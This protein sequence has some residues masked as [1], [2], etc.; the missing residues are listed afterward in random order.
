MKKPLSLLA[1]QKPFCPGTL[2]RTG[3]DRKAK[4]TCWP[5]GGFES[6]A[7]ILEK[8]KGT[9]KEKTKEER[10]RDGETLARGRSSGW[11]KRNK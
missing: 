8:P 7:L 9:G 10:N 6:Q 5:S 11:Q 2:R 3:S 4:D 1:H